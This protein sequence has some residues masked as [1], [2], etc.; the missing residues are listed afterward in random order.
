M[1]LYNVSAAGIVCEKSRGGLAA[2]QC[3]TRRGIG[4]SEAIV[5]A[6]CAR[7]RPARGIKTKIP[8]FGI[9]GSNVV[10]FLRVWRGRRN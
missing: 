4:E 10:A 2:C 9:I 7:N 6:L 3:S 1:L 8:S 5:E